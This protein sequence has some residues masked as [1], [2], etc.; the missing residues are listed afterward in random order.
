MTELIIN[1]MGRVEFKYG[2]KN[3]EHKLSNKG[4][5]LI[6]LLMLNIKNGISREKLISYLW[7]D[8]DD[9]AARY[10]L[11]YNLWN[12]KKVIHA[13]E[14]GEDLILSTKDYCHLNAKYAFESDMLKLMKFE[15]RGEEQ[16]IE[17]LYSYKQLFRGIS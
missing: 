14:C 9:E 8:S 17:D 6:S 1:L 13:D 7:A 12:I 2:E 5:A 4:V 3:L 11:R 10:N 15:C 16:S